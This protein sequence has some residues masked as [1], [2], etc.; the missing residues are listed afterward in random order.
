MSFNAVL[1]KTNGEVLKLEVEF[2]SDYRGLEDAIEAEGL[3]TIHTIKTQ[4]L[5]NKLGIHL[6]GFVDRYM[7][8][9]DK[10]NNEL[11]CRISGYDFLASDM[12]LV[13]TDDKFNPLPLEVGEVDILYL[14]LT[15]G[16]IS[17]GSPAELASF[18]E[19]YGINPILPSFPTK[20]KVYYVEEYPNLAFVVYDWRNITKEELE[21]CGAEM[22]KYADYLVKHFTSA[23]E[24]SCS[25][26]PD[27]K[28]Y[29]KNQIINNSQYFTVVIQAILEPGEPI[30]VNNV[31]DFINLDLGNAEI[32]KEDRAYEHY[33]LEVEFYAR[34]PNHPDES[35]AEGRYA[36]LVYDDDP[37]FIPNFPDTFKI[38]NS[39]EENEE[40]TFSVNYGG[41]IKE[42]T[43]GMNESIN[44]DFDYVRDKKVPTSRRVGE[45]K[46]TLRKFI[47]GKTKLD[48]TLSIRT[49]SFCIEDEAYIFDETKEIVNPDL[50]KR[51]CR[52]IV[53]GNGEFY[54]IE[55][56]SVDG[57]YLILFGSVI[58]D[59]DEKN[60]IYLVPLDINKQTRIIDEF[61]FQDDNKKYRVEETFEYK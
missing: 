32:K 5:S 45:M 52:S 11:A 44:L 40:V 20:P 22:F 19:K 6:I 23:E 57:K 14:Y 38:L 7:E 36:I 15:E 49:T 59:D 51:D 60:P 54:S 47:M 8:R 24:V 50:D 56:I 27:G 9:S 55:Y 30:I 25:I 3:S 28:Y 46:I 12:I 33:V 39:D 4:D 17:G 35:F 58:D 41:E 43:L 1:I 48:K 31:L 53:V 26:S 29:L 18:S 16:K 21:A 42:Y 2:D 61:I 37:P 13:K 34:W 10:D